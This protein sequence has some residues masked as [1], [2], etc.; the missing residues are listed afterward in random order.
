MDS[1]L[2]SLYPTSD[3]ARAFAITLPPRAT[4]DIVKLGRALLD[5][6]PPFLRHLMDLRDVG[7]GIFGVKT[8]RQIRDD[9]DREGS[10]R[11]NFFRVRSVAENELILGEDDKHLDFRVSVL[12]R[13]RDAGPGREIVATTV[14]H[15]HNLLG[16][17]YLAVVGPFHCMIMRSNLRRAAKREWQEPDL[18]QR[19][20]G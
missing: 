6:P 17:S 16:R 9:L 1:K 14:A 11:I 19:L 15:A 10:A 7:V 4:R 20:A 18:P 3:F 5:S 13:P 12:L 2:R 8:S